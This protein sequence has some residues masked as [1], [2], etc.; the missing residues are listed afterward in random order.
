[1]REL[2]DWIAEH[3]MGWL[4]TQ[5]PDDYTADETTQFYKHVANGQTQWH[6]I[7]GVP[8]RCTHH[9]EGK[10]F[11]HS[12]KNFQPTTDPSQAMLV[13][14]KCVYNLSPYVV[15]IAVSSTTGFFVCDTEHYRKDI[16]S[17]AETLPL[18]I[19]QMAQKLFTP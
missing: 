11:Q 17:S 16:R 14:E 2:D 6:V 9:P 8:Y 13:L 7:V 10:P 4:E 19:C 3:V 15:T 12:Y 5:N 18:T 1:M